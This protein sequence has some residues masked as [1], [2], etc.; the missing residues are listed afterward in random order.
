[1]TYAETSFLQVNLVSSVTVVTGLPPGPPSI[2]GPVLPNDGSLTVAFNPPVDQGTTPIVHYLIHLQPDEREIM[3]DSSPCRVEDL[4]NGKVYRVRVRA[5][6]SIGYGA[7]SEL[8]SEIVPGMERGFVRERAKKISLVGDRYR[9]SRLF[10]FAVCDATPCLWLMIIGGL[11]DAP[12]LH[13]P[14]EVGD[15]RITLAFDPP[16]NTGGVPITSYIAKISPG[17]R[18]VVFNPDD[19]FVIQG[20]RNGVTYTV[21]LAAMNKQGRGPWSESCEAMPG[22]YFG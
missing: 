15:G 10:S 3:V 17:T 12:I 22:K 11:A 1:M 7:W 16:I 18:E 4:V 8:S 5:K 2:T 21:A 13:K 20:L 6:S 14:L 19:R 9:Y